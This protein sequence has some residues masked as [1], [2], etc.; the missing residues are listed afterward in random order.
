MN[1]WIIILA[2]TVAVLALAVIGMVCFCCRRMKRE[3]DNSLVTAIREQD[4]LA[5]ELERVRIEKE[6]FERVLRSELTTSDAPDNLSQMNNF[7]K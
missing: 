7:L 3:K 2:L 5:H 4:R 1:E 6:A